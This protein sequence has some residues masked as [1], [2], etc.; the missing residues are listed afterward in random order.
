MALR[1]TIISENASRLGEKATKVFGVHGGTIGRARDNEWILPDPERYLS[2]KHARVDFRGGMYYLADTSSNGTYVNGAQVPLGKFHDYAMNDGDT[3]RLG[4]YQLL[5]SIE[6][7]TDFPADRDASVASGGKA[8]AVAARNSTADDIGADLNLIELLEPSNRSNG[9]VA[10]LARDAYGQSVGPDGDM[11]PLP[12]AVPAA[13]PWHMMTRPLSID[14]AAPAA[15]RAAS[16][17][18]RAAAAPRPP[19]V[20]LMD[21]EFDA[22][23]VAFCRGAG[24]DPRSLTADARATALQRAGQLLRESLLGLM[25]LD[26]VRGEF[27]NR[28][29][30]PAPPVD[31]SESAISFA[32][33]VDET[34]LRLLNIAS[35]R[36][37]SVEAMRQKYRDLKAQG[38]STL[39]AMRAALDEILA[40]FDPKELEERFARGTKRGVFGAQ[41][42][43]K[44]WGLYAELYASLSQ[45]LPEGFPHLFIEAFAKA[46][47]AKLRSVTPPRRG[48]FIGDASDPES[49][50]T[51][52]H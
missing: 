13:V 50:T 6:G 41:N 28:L 4:E 17:A 34:L 15:E 27:R 2:G 10:L 25:D 1:L 9:N 18:D 30:I 38:A 31:E 5:V 12:E 26:Q 29:H 14:R 8:A 22:G 11:S 23:L 46:Y 7:G 20:P 43:D 21:G 37:G 33:G 35:K 36:A 52:D 48:S 39:S 45:R 49:Q 44:Y 51:G 32:Q 42:K 3:I 40:R 16:A 24:I 47:E 19:G